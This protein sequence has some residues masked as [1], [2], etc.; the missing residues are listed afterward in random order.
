LVVKEAPAEDIGPSQAL[1]LAGLVTVVVNNVV[2]VNISKR[3]PRAVEQY[4]TAGSISED[5]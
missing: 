1:D 5:E 3:V 4:I 2:F